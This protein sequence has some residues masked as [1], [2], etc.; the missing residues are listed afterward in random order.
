[1]VQVQLF[2]EEVAVRFE[3]VGFAAVGCPGFPI[4]D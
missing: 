1:V 3:T 4:S 2:V